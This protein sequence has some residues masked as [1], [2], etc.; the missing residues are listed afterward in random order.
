[1]EAYDTEGVEVIKRNG[2]VAN[3]MR[4]DHTLKYT[5]KSFLF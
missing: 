5:G 4:D 3:Y 2:S 1:L